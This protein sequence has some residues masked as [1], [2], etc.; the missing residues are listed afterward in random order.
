VNLRNIEPGTISGALIT[1]CWDGR[2]AYLSLDAPEFDLSA[3]ARRRD[4]FDGLRQ[5]LEPLG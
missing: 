5:H 2:D 3:D 1:F 4:L